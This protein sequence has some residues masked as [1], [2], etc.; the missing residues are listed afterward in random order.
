MRLYEPRISLLIPQIAIL[1]GV[2]TGPRGEAWFSLLSA[3]NSVW[4]VSRFA[5]NEA[6]MG[7]VDWKLHSTFQ[8]S[9]RLHTWRKSSL[10]A[11]LGTKHVRAV[12]YCNHSSLLII[13]NSNRR[14]FTNLVNLTSIKP[15]VWNSDGL[16]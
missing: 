13:L 8:D 14:S 3:L 7:N 2:Y 11:R 4:I 16:R 6:C 5:N 15:D 12:C 1:I 10:E 9:Y